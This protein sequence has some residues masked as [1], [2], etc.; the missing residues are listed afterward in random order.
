MTTDYSPLTT[1]YSLLTTHYS[2]LATHYRDDLVRRVKALL[3]TYYLL[4]TTYY[5]ILRRVKALV[6][7]VLGDE[8]DALHLRI[9]EVFGTSWDPASTVRA[10]PVAI[11][12]LG[13]G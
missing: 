10:A 5:L 7:P 1:Y 2:L 13:L 4:L 8:Y 12:G 11:L 6:L 3:T 9:T